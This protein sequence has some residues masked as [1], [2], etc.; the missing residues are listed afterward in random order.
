[1]VSASASAKLV[2]WWILCSARLGVEGRRP[3]PSST[4]D[5]DSFFASTFCG[6]AKTV[7]SPSNCTRLE[8]FSEIVCPSQNNVCHHSFN[9]TTHCTD[10]YGCPQECERYLETCCEVKCCED[11]CLDK[12]V[13]CTLMEMATC[14]DARLEACPCD[15]DTRTATEYCTELVG[16]T[17]CTDTCLEFFFGLLR[18]T[19][20][21]FAP[22]T[23]FHLPL[24]RRRKNCRAIGNLQGWRLGCSL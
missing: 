4:C 9:L 5:T 7:T 14:K 16:E 11:S 3:P 22:D 12:Q 18:R 24:D 23:Y 21:S 17:G 13:L 1:M 10:N 15:S 19:G 8:S 20:G 6:L 2:A